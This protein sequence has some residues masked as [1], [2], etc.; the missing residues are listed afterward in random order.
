MDLISREEVKELLDARSD[1]KL[2]NVLSRDSFAKVHIPGSIN[3]P[4]KEDN[5]E[6][7]FT[8][9]VPDKNARIVVYCS[10]PD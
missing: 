3:V 7:R 6:K 1:F 8:E 4:L 5:F 9:V 10:S 2:V